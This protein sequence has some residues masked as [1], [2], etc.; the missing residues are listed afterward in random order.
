MLLSRPKEVRAQFPRYEIPGPY[1]HLGGD[2]PS[3]ITLYSLRVAQRR[4][5]ARFAL[6]RALSEFW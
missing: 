6:A 4:H 2:F 1:R 3:Y 5:L